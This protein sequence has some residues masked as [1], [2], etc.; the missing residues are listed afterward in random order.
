MEALVSPIADVFHDE[1][2]PFDESA[3]LT[4]DPAAAKVLADKLPYG[5]RFFL[6]EKITPVQAAFLDRNGFILFARVAS[7]GE[8]NQILAEV[9]T[10]EARVL[11]EGRDAIFGVPVWVGR[12]PDG[13]PWLQRMGMSSVL[14]EYIH[15][16]VRDS[17]FEPI[18]T[19]IGADARVGDREKDGVVFNRYARVD[20]S[21]R[22]GLGWHTD[23]LRD[24][25]YNWKIPGPMLNIGLHFD[26]ILPQEGSL[27]LIPGTHTQG[28][29]GMLFRKIHFVSDG[30]DRNEVCVETWP[31]DLSVHDGRMW[32]RVAESPHLGERSV[33][34]SMYTPYVVDTY[35]P[36]DEKSGTPLYLKV[37]TAIMRLK[38]RWHDW[39]TGNRA[40]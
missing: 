26:R 11:T 23:A 30:P 32:H 16:F 28:F 38:G 14:S 12:G 10:V 39:R 33:R 17:R 21:L 8:V 34:R 2:A 3:L 4:L 25:V 20:G 36:K 18:R 15:G 22:P 13:K 31:G 9:D 35:H 40:N 24:V 1:P 5:T 29:F 19:L 7:L 37:F 6:R 27:R